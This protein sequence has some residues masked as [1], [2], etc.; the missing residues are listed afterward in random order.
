MINGRANGKNDFTHVSHRG[1]SVVDYVLVPHEQIIDVKSMNVSLM[2]ETVK[3]FAL[4]GCEKIPDHSVLLW[5]SELMIKDYDDVYTQNSQTSRKSFNVSNLPNEFLNDREA[6]HLIQRTID[7]IES[8]ISEENG[9]NEAYSAFM[10]LC[11]SEMDAKLKSF[12]S[13]ALRPKGRKMKYKKYW[14]EELETQ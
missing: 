13:N 8:S 12:S 1:R 9:A 5:E 10:E 6:V 2:S 3:L 11:H 4:N 14:N 7:R